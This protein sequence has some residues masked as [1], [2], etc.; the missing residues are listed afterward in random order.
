LR[1]IAHGTKY[2]F[3]IQSSLQKAVFGCKNN[4]ILKK[5]K[6]VF[7]EDLLYMPQNTKYDKQVLSAIE[8]G[9]A[10]KRKGTN[11]RTK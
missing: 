2:P 11:A 5:T 7:W 10:T 3:S 6:M 9:D 1:Y 8:R 4:T